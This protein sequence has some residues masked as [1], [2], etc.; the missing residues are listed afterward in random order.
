MK[1]TTSVIKYEIGYQLSDQCFSFRELV[2]EFADRIDTV[3]FPWTD[4]A[5]CRNA[6]ANNKGH[7]NWMAQFALERDLSWL[8]SQGIKLNLLFNANCYGELAVSKY[9]E[10]HIISILEH[11]TDI[12]LRPE[13]IT[14]TSPAI[15][16][17]VKKSFPDILVRASVNMRIGTVEGMEYLADF[18]DEYNMQRDYNRDFKRIGQLK[19]WADE[20][21][22]GLYLLANSGCFR[23]C[24]AQIF[25]DNLVSHDGAVAEW[26]NI[27]GWYQSNCR[28]YLRKKENWATI[29]QATWIRPEDI[30]HYGEYF[31][32]IKLA[33]RQHER[34]WLILNA[35]TQERYYG[36]ITDLLEP[37]FSK[38]IAP[39]AIPNQLFPEDWFE[40]T[41]NCSK[42][43]RECG[44]CKKVLEELLTDTRGFSF[45]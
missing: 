45:G 5:T 14:T 22:K 30:H 24:S 34:P 10:N 38:E 41:T 3:Y 1:E 19:K 20:N 16:Q 42:N 11:L 31:P 25:H 6:I 27:D 7:T 29:L 26:D 43:C 18:F 23:N 12:R 9:L 8:R 35:Y 32:V 28:R 39:Y 33:T 13:I 36:S 15:A 17:M 4:V 21:G 44:Y 2:S 40:R 37:G